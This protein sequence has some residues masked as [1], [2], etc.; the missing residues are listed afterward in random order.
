MLSAQVSLQCH[1]TIRVLEDFDGGCVIGEDWYINQ[2]TLEND[3]HPL[4]LKLYVILLW[5]MQSKR[6]VVFITLTIRGRTL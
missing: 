4:M 2:V 3:L 1:D 5:N 6:I